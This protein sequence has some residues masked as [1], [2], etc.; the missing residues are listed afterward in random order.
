MLNW[1]RGSLA[2]MCVVGS[3][4]CAANAEPESSEPEVGKTQEA[5]S[6][7]STPKL[8][9]PLWTRA[10]YDA[11]LGTTMVDVSTSQVPAID[12]PPD[13]DPHNGDMFQMVQAFTFRDGRRV[14]LATLSGVQVGPGGGC[15]H[16]SINANLGEKIYVGAVVRLQSQSFPSAG[17]A[18]PA[19]VVVG[20]WLHDPTVL[21]DPDHHWP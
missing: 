2:L 17:I 15:I 18:A 21:L 12:L 8:L 1:V 7:S 11:Q 4:G 3:V 6:L 5:L 9:I 10:T 20:D 19:L 13:H 14:N 16:F